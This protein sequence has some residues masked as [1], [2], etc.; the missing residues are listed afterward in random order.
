MNRAIYILI[1][2]DMQITGIVGVLVGLS[3][4]LFEVSLMKGGFSNMENCINY[5]SQE[6]ECV[7]DAS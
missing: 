1:T 4:I 3:I 5:K 2:Y 7:F 6:R